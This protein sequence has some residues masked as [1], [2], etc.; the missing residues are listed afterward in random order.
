MLPRGSMSYSLI[1]LSHF[2]SHAD[3]GLGRRGAAVTTGAASPS[4]HA[5]AAG[6]TSSPCR[7]TWRAVVRLPATVPRRST[8]RSA[9][10]PQR[11][12]RAGARLG[13]GSGRAQGDPCAGD[14]C[15]QRGKLAAREPRGPGAG[16]DPGE[17]MCFSLHLEYR[18]AST[19]RKGAA[20]R[21]N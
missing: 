7:S 1:S 13:V 19:C 2:I 11:A 20:S 17:D 10:H 15:E 12:L 21:V 6:M 8:W 16:A 5:V 3:A 14:R 9:E 18:P 4:E